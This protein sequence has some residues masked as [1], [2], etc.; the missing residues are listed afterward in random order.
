MLLRVEICLRTIFISSLVITCENIYSM[1]ALSYC[2]IPNKSKKASIRWQDSV[3][4][5]SVYWPTSEPNA[6]EWR[7]DVTA[8]ALWGEVC[9]MQVLPMRVDPF[10]FR[11]QGNGATPSQYIDT[12]QKARQLIAL[13]LC[14]WE[15]LYNETFQQTSCPLLSKLS[16]RVKT[17]NLGTIS[18]FW[19][20]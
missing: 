7:N 2:S 10:A 19:G 3:P 4:P 12:T 13:E 14:R 20:S 9:A 6:G 1:H 18:P 11:F 8:A 5:I 16:K 17:T 15:F